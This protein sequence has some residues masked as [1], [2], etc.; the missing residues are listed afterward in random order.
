MRLHIVN[1]FA[2]TREQPRILEHRVVY[3]DAIPTE[4][5][6]F[7]HQPCGMGQR[8]HRNR[9]VSGGHAAEFGSRNECC[10]GAQICGAERSNDTRR[11]GA[12]NQNV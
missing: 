9:S 7:P 5:A 6:S 1:D 2:H 8:P 10:L 3:G 4:L 11:P 12:D